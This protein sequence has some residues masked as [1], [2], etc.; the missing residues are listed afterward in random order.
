MVTSPEV[1][2]FP[3]NYEVQWETW[4]S[5][6]NDGLN[7][8]RDKWRDPEPRMI[9]GL[10]SRRIITQDGV[11][12]AQDEDNLRLAVPPDFAWAGRDIVTIPATNALGGRYQIKGAADANVGFHGWRPGLIL[13]CQRVEG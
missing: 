10:T 5:D 12:A 6:D 2:P 3:A 13:E 11:H 7:N 4:Y 1:A 9:I 8:A